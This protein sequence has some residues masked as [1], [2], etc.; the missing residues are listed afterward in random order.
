MQYLILWVFQRHESEAF[1]RDTDHFLT[2]R[3][4]SEASPPGPSPPPPPEL[5]PCYLSIGPHEHSP[6]CIVI[7]LRGADDSNLTCYGT[8]HTTSAT[9]IPGSLLNQINRAMLEDCYV[10]VT[11][12]DLLS[13]VPIHDNLKP[14]RERPSRLLRTSCAPSLS[15]GLLPECRYRLR[16]WMQRDIGIVMWASCS[17]RESEG[18]KVMRQRGLIGLQIVGHGHR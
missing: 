7:Y 15:V 16:V 18:K 14:T 13:P 11:Y 8:V 17:C 10:V 3:L 5:R 6:S 2:S 4:P 12:N 9:T 1:R